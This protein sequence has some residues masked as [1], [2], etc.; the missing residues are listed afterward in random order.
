MNATRTSAS[1]SRPQI[2]IGPQDYIRRR[3]PKAVYRKV[4]SPEEAIRGAATPFPLRPAQVTVSG[5]RVSL[6]TLMPAHRW[7]RGPK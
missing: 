7:Q 6:L 1:D 4:W 3:P 5:R 2:G